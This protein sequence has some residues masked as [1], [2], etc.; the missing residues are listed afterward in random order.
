MN[1]RPNDLSASP[2]THQS[3]GE[4]VLRLGEPLVAYDVMTRGLELWPGDVR[5]R[6][7]QALALARSGA[8]ERAARQTDPIARG[9]ARR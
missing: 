9:R 8:G 1:S 5:L 7:L 6:Q 2:R 3:L 4:K